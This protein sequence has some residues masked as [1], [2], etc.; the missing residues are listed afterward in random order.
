MRSSATS[1]GQQLISIR[2]LFTLHYSTIFFSTKTVFISTTTTNVRIVHSCF[3]PPHFD[4]R[5]RILH[6][7][8]FLSKHFIRIVPHFN[9]S[10]QSVLCYAVI[11]DKGQ[12]LFS[13]YLF[14]TRTLGLFNLQQFEYEPYW[15]DA[16]ENSG[17]N[18]HA[19]DVYNCPRFF[20]ETLIQQQM[21]LYAQ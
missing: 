17:I 10:K 3:H 5:C 21:A 2:A 20:P 11:R 7:V 1:N 6:S 13:F 9:F 14:V 19:N 12:N 18:K 8:V 15:V 16:Y 4:E